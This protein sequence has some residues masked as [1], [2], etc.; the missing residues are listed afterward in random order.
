[1]GVY[2]NNGEEYNTS[3][4]DMNVIAQMNSAQTE[5]SD[6]ITKEPQVIT[7]HNYN[8][9][10]R[11]VKPRQ[12]LNPLKTDQ[13]SILKAHSNADTNENQGWHKEFGQRGRDALIKEL[14]KLHSR[15]ALLPV[16]KENLSS[17]DR[18]RALRYL[19]FIKAK[20]VVLLRCEGAL[21][22]GRRGSI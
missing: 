17:S 14:H 1:M 13:Q 21:M 18:K 15:D 9:R 12:Q 19:M 4:H 10:Q 7:T 5:T 3:A 11:W 16:K 6:D 2:N 8:L 20:D 22:G